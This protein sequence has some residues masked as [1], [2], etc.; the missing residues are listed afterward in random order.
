[1]SV[2]RP[3]P[4]KVPSFWGSA[5]RAF[6]DKFV[7]LGRFSKRRCALIR[8]VSRG[9]A[10]SGLAKTAKV[11]R[12]CG[13]LGCFCHAPAPPETI[14]TPRKPKTPKDKTTRSVSTLPV[15][16][17]IT[18]YN[19]RNG[20]TRQKLTPWCPPLGGVEY[21]NPILF[22]EL[23]TL[24]LFFAAWVGGCIQGVFRRGVRAGRFLQSRLCASRLGAL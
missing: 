2:P 17:G 3:K 22:F 9:L 21:F 14:S 8:V 11:G 15:C 1:M 18:R 13:I 20:G 23:E 10:A 19:P 24:R 16:F 4:D 6:I 7:P 5:G 12:F